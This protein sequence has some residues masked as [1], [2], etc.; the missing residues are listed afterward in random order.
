M[1]SFLNTNLFVCLKFSKILSKQIISF[2]NYVMIEV[3]VLPYKTHSFNFFHFD[4][5][6]FWK[7]Q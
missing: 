3:K 5:N 6:Y 1:I 2:A 7:L 4:L